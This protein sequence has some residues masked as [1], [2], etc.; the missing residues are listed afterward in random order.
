MVLIIDNHCRVDAYE[1]TSERSDEN[2]TKKCSRSVGCRRCSGEGKGIRRHERAHERAI[3]CTPK[4]QEPSSG[5][6]VRPFQRGDDN[7]SE[8]KRLD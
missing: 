7:C 4:R 2:G 6:P 3:V 5:S 1:L 8:S